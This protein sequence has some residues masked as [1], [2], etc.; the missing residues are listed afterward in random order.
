MALKII[1]PKNLYLFLTTFFLS[2]LLRKRVKLSEFYSFSS[3]IRSFLFDLISKQEDSLM[4]YRLRS[5]DLKLCIGNF[6]QLNV[7]IIVGRNGSSLQAKKILAQQSSNLALEGETDE[8]EKNNL[9][10][11]KSLS[12]QALFL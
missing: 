2:D 12:K 8:D 9:S 4:K 7:V 5:G 10:K 1:E 6:I 3:C 11:S